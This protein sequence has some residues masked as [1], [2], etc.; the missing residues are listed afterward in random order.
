M[1]DDTDSFSNNND[2]DVNENSVDDVYQQT[3]LRHRL[4]TLNLLF[5]VYVQ[6]TFV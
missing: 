4:L 3:F 6:L 2:D 5:N 1:C